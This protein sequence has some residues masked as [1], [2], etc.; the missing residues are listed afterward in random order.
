M[1]VF[2]DLSKKSSKVTSPSNR[3][4][5]I[6]FGRIP[7]QTEILDGLLIQMEGLKKENEINFEWVSMTRLSLL[8]DET[9][10]VV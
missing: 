2:V 4:Y 9:Q 6:L 5:W 8:L 3:V 10:S 1:N 7:E